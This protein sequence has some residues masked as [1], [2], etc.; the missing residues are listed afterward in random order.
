M[1]KPTVLC[2]SIVCLITSLCACRKSE[3]NTATPTPNTSATPSPIV[4]QEPGSDVSAEPNDSPAT[5]TP[6]PVITP[7]PTPR[8]AQT[9]SICPS[10]LITSGYTTP[11]KDV[12]AGYKM[13][14]Y[15]EVDLTN[16][17]INIFVKNSE[18]GK[19]DKLLNRFVCSGGTS[20]QPTKKGEFYIK[21]NA[22]QKASTGQSVKY[23]RYYFKKYDSYAY[24]VTRYSN[25]YMFHSFTF[26]QKN[27]K[28][29]P[30]SYN[31]GNTG[32]AGCLRMLMGHAKWIYENIDAGTY[33]VV[34]NS[35]KSDASLRKLLKKLPPLGYDM[36]K[37]FDPD[38]MTGI[39]RCDYVDDSSVVTPRPTP[40]PTVTPI[41]TPTPEITPSPTPDTTPVSGPTNTP[42]P[43]P[44]A[45]PTPT[46][47][48]GPAT[49]DS[50]D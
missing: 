7:K 27:G 24:Y 9:E 35:R 40:T 50:G 39:V 31:L 30:K 23:K 14:Y 2:V 25:E 36:T 1:K 3:V 49:T 32:S 45:T 22:E 29:V 8:P 5:V 16:Q 19:Y 10:Y 11:L 13:P 21:S 48:P 6:T 20:A 18:T 41:I 42:T 38:T 4:S 33:V 34:N 43:T 37:D 12:P 15:I 46:P 44:T 47:L 28:L 17:C 26:Y